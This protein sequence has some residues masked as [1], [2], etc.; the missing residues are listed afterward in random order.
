MRFPITVVLML[1]LG[2]LTGIS[3]GS[4]LLI[5]A[6]A[7]LKNTQELTAKHAELTVAAIERGVMNN[8]TPSRNML[9]EIARRV[10]NGKLDL[11]DREWLAATLSVALAAAPQMGGVAIW[12]PEVDE[13]WVRR[14]AENEITVR[15]VSAQ[16]RAQFDTITNRFDSNEGISWGRPTFFGS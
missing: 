8:L 15:S 1:A 16:T 4:V 11:A 3:V 7:S 5:S 13:L 6:T 2:G 14:D 10:T 9:N 12:Q